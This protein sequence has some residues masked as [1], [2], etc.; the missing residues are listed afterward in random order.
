MKYSWRVKCIIVDTN[1]TLTFKFNRL[2]EAVKFAR[3]LC[4][5]GDTAFIQPN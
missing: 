5:H 4:S 2:I 3:F 1:E